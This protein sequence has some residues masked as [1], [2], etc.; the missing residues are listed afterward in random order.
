MTTSRIFTDLIFF[1]F[2]LLAKDSIKYVERANKNYC[3]EF[4]IYRHWHGNLKELFSS[5]FKFHIKKM[6][7]QSKVKSKYLYYL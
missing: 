7:N 5:L 4:S 6:N 1:I 3:A 2:R